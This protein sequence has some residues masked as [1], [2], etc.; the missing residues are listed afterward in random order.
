MPTCRADCIHRTCG[1]Y[2]RTSGGL[3]ILNKRYRERGVCNASAPIVNEQGV[4]ATFQ[5]WNKS[6]SQSM[7]LTK[8]M[9][10]EKGVR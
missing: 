8:W 9:D 10:E 5:N 7:S 2:R 4:C 3:F 6:C 1:R